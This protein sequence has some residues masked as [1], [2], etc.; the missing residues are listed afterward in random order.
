MLST[1]INDMEDMSM[2]EHNEL[3]KINSQSIENTETLNAD[4]LYSRIREV[5]TQARGHQNRTH[6]VLN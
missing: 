2:S 3:E 4:K 1:K 5:L 6:C